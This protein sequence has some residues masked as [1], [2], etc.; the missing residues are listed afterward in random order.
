M[1]TTY[2]INSIWVICASVF[3]FMMQMGFACCESG[4]ARSKNACNIWLKNLLDF[5]IGAIVYYFIGFGLMYGDDWH[6]LIG[7]NGF[8]NPFSQDLQ[9]WQTY[10]GT[11]S[12]QAFLLFQTMFCATTATIISGSV[13][14]RFKLGTYVGVSAFMTGIVYPVI[15]HWIWGGGWLSQIGFSDFAGSGA[16][17]LCGATAAFV[18]AFSVGP[19]IGKY[20]NGKSVAIPG[21]NIPMAMLGG[22]ILWVG[23]YGFNPGSELAFDETTIYTTVTTT[24]SASAGGLA[25]LAYT[26]IRYGKPDPTLTMNGA[27]AG[28]VAICTGV[29]EVSY[30]GSILEGLIAGLLLPISVSFVDNKLHVDDPAGAIS[31]HGTSGFVGVLLPGFFSTENGLFYGGGLARLGAQLVGDV[32]IVG[33]TALCVFILM[34]VLKKTVGIRVSR[35]IEMK[36]LDIT[37]H[38]MEAYP[39]ATN[40]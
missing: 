8:F 30:T 11:L 7:I 2:L 16:V 15:G 34:T 1:S 37:E 36:G 39:A 20:V 9:I 13:A 12:P 18:C 40:Y 38:G 21:H 27:L 25:A 19:R 10:E 5:M 32:C 14:E 28:L 33:F 31:L 35:E 23:W 3:V 22:F 26:W 24:L 6:G 29:A 4:F 17:H